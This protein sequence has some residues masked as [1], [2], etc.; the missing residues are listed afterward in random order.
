M[1]IKQAL[2][3]LHMSFGKPRFLKNPF[4]KKNKYYANKINPICFFPNSLDFTSTDH[5]KKYIF[6]IKGIY[7]VFFHI[8]YCN[9]TLKIRINSLTS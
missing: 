9:Q 7:W 6:I 2:V 3:L 5:K 1:K 8:R 4:L